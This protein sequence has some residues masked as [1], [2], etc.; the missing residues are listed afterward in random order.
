MAKYITQFLPEHH[1][2]DPW[3]FV[4]Q[5]ILVAEKKL[6]RKLVDGEVVH[7][8]NWFELDNSPDNLL[9]LRD[10][11]EHSRI[12]EMQ[13]RFLE[14]KGL[15]KEFVEW[16]HTNRDVPDPRREF[17]RSIIESSEALLRK[18]SPRLEPVFKTK[19]TTQPKE[20]VK[21]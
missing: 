14:A 15:L 1:K 16:F 7:H 17:L 19:Q 8:V 12:G 13:A 4:P 18:N 3:G 9:V 6:E 10:Q 21:Q 11:L 2:R 20:D 5:H